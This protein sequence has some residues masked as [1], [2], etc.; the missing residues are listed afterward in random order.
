MLRKS[1]FFA[2]LLLFLAGCV[3]PVDHPAPTAFPAGYMPTVIYLT[4][5]S[6]NSTLSAVITPSVVPTETPTLIPPSPA[7]TGTRTAAPGSSLAAIQINKPGPGSRVASPLE[8]QVLAL[9]GDSKKIDVSL[10]GEDGRLLAEIIRPV[11]GSPYGD[12]LSLKIPFE[13]RA[14][15]EVGVIQISTKNKAGVLQSLISER[16]LLLSSGV[17]QINPAGN[18]IYERVTLSHLPPNADVS[19]GVLSLQGQFTPYNQQPIILELISDTGQGMSLRV[20]NSPNLDPRNFTTTL[21][22]KVSGPTQARL[23]IH[24]EDNVLKGPVYIFSQEITLNP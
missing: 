8:I 19:G 15:A 10:F 4:A 6:I 2:F 11:L 5:Q 16:I 22:Y 12:Y 21:P 20:L 14:A 13:I 3:L 7:P 1:M 18:T 24:Q 17:S 23:F 9:A